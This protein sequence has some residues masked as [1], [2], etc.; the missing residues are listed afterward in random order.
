MSDPNYLVT[1]DIGSSNIVI[2]GREEPTPK[3]LFNPDFI[4]VPS[5]GFDR[6]YVHD[7]AKATE[8]LVQAIY[9]FEKKIKRRV[10]RATIA[11]GGT[12]L[13]SQSVKT[14]IELRRNDIEISERD[15]RE[16]LEKA[17]LLFMDKYPNKKVLHVFPSG[18]R[19]DERDV[20][21]SPVGMFGS[22]LDVRVTMVTAEEHHVDALTKVINSSGI[23]VHEIVA[24][25][26][27]D[28]MIC[29][30]YQQKKQGCVL[31]N[32]G[33]ETTQVSTYERG[34]L[35]TLRVFPI[36]S[37]DVT[38]D[39]ALGLQ[40][41]IEQAE[42]VKQG[43]NNTFPQKQTR[44]II[45]ARFADIIDSVEKHLKSIKKNR[46][47]PAGIIWTGGGSL[48]PNLAALGKA[49]LRVPSEFSKVEI[50][51]PEKKRK[52]SLPP[53]ATT[54][55]GLL[56]LYDI[57]SEEPRKFNLQSIT[58]YLSYWFDQLRP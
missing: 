27:A 4:M 26:L 41:P 8:S 50:D 2:A 54:A 51:I 17:E 49:T 48:Y 45:D 38:N 23:Q 21:G 42:D 36:G 15:I 33:A 7:S 22:T 40:I 14:G 6:G 13:G 52:Q 29:L 37:D 56:E 10:T 46:L 30:N 12:D 9:R 16:V 1:I 57:D 58:S 47:L 18:Y 11:I 32:V 28:S 44:E 31:V 20:L 55:L 25:P 34:L 53:K 35:S 43:K 3:G 39:L 5:R 19:V 24:G